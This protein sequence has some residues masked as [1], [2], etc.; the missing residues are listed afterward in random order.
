M[1]FY[2]ICKLLLRMQQLNSNTNNFSLHFFAKYIA[3]FTC[4]YILTYEKFFFPFFYNM[5]YAFHARYI[6][7]GILFN[8][9]ILYNLFSFFV[10]ILYM[11]VVGG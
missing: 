5:N 10:H 3:N 4:I 9:N 11:F 7:K 2:A 8:T 1:W 6:Q